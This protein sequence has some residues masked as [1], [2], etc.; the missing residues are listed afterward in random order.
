[1][2][3]RAAVSR[4]IAVAALLVL[5]VALAACSFDPPEPTFVVSDPH[6]KA[7]PVEGEIDALH[8]DSKTAV[9]VTKSSKQVW[10]STTCPVKP[11]ADF[12]K[13]RVGDRIE[14]KVVVENEQCYITAIKVLK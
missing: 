7:G 13:L 3:R 8:A 6:P 10:G 5:V 4:R 1:M 14:G 11:V 9:V 2:R 12:Q